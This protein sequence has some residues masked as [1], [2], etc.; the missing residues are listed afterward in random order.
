ML[1]ETCEA[2]LH[3]IDE[4]D[5]SKPTP[6]ML[7]TALLERTIELIDDGY[8]VDDIMFTTFELIEL[9]KT[10]SISENQAKKFKSDHYSETESL[11]N[12]INELR[13]N[14]YGGNLEYLIELSDTGEKGGAKNKKHH[15]FKIV[16]KNK[17]KSNNES[18]K[19]SNSIRY[20]PVK[21]PKPNWFARPF[22]SIELSSWRL[23][24]YAA[25]PS[26]A[27]LF[28]C[29][30]FVQSFITPST[31]EL[32]FFLLFIIITIYVGK[33]IF[34]FYEANHLRITIAPQWLMRFSQLTAQIESI[35]L[36]KIRKN[37][38]PYRKLEFVIYEGKCPI[39]NNIVE[40]EKGKRQ[41]KGRLIGICNESP[42]EH[43][44]SFDHVTKKGKLIT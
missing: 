7:L 15:F 24:I 29:V 13:D 2:T 41:F 22:M 42:R 35:K 34:P 3:L 39:C 36:D 25:I 27:L 31:S 37:G 4:I 8:K 44:F 11:L 16:E 6:K 14:Q 19:D 30:L 40:V 17:V 32:V 5:Y 1:K 10:G 33:L 12:K 23:F 9:V 26:S 38:R 43:V 18:T 20:E 21:L 28:G